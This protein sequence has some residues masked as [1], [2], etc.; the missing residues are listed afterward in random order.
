MPKGKKKK[1]S[2]RFNLPPDDPPTVTLGEVLSGTATGNTHTTV[3][4][5]AFVAQRRL[6]CPECNYAQSLTV[7]PDAKISCPKCTERFFHKHIPQMQDAPQEPGPVLPPAPKPKL[8]GGKR[9]AK[10]CHEPLNPRFCIIRFEDDNTED[11]LWKDKRMGSLRHVQLIVERNRDEGMG[12][13]TIVRE[14][15]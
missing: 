4:L 11:R 6:V 14:T 1:P 3:T 10:V 15:P 13:W 5:T 2:P 12:G 8:K 9:Y 7:L